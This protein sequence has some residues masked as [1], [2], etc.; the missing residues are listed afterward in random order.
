VELGYV[1]T[2]GINL[3]RIDNVNRKTGDLLDGVLN[4][5]NPNFGP[6]L[7]VTNGV[8]SSYNALTAE[9]RHSFG[10]GFT[11]L[12]NYRWSKWID[13]GSDTS[14]GQFLD[15]SEPGKGAENIACLKCERGPSMFDIPQRFAA[16]G[17][18]TPKPF[19]D[20][21]LLGKLG[22]GWEVSAVF[23]GQSGRPFSVWNGAS[24]TA[25]GDY[26][27]DGGGGAVGGGYYDRPNAPAPGAVSTSFSNQQFID[28]IFLPNAFPTPSLGTNGNLGRNT[29]RGPHQIT[30]DA[31]VSRSFAF[32]ERRALSFR[33]EAFNAA[34]KVNLY[35]PNSDLSL[36][37]RPD[38]TYSN[39]SSFG[40]STSA[41]DGRSVQLSLRFTF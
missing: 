8:N 31:A 21:S 3:E 16:T 9:V 5:V 15:N 26:N 11:L 1:G 24:F 4:N 13:D 14:T 32:A 38:K 19:T 30:L 17:V 28:G 27:A 6:L 10:R 34:N 41:F 22:N 33:A 23:T 40:K 2:N 35:L 25:G 18:W 29:F 20:H 37:L 39:T 36:A 12:A 7:F